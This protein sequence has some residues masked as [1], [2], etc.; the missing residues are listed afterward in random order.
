M[1]N[2]E[3][4]YREY[5]LSGDNASLQSAR[6]RISVA[7]REQGILLELTT[8]NPSQQ[9][10]LVV[11]TDLER[12]II[13]RGE[14]IAQLGKPVDVPSAEII[15]RGRVDPALAEVRAVAQ[16]M[17]AEERRLLLL[18]DAD[19]ERRARQAK[20][21]IVLGSVL[22]LAT[23]LA[24][25]WIVSRL[26][27]RNKESESK[28]KQLNRLYAMVGGINA[29]GVRVRDRDDLFT[30]ACRIAVQHGEFAMAWIGAIDPTELRMVPIAWAG[31]DEQ[32]IAAIRDL[33]S[34]GNDSLLRQTMA[35]QVVTTKAA[36]V[37]NDVQKDE[38]LVLGRI[39]AKAHIRSI[40]AL[41]LI[42]SD[43]VIGVLVLYARKAEFFD[44]DGMKLLTDLAGYIAFAV[45]H[46][47]KQERLDNLAY[48]DEPTLAPRSIHSA[49]DQCRRR[50][51]TTGS[52][53]D[54]P[55][56]LQAIQ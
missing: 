11:A 36:V 25:A 39:H 10:R 40:A 45:D 37:S 41:P 15:R 27:R 4:G 30:S 42:V 9:H 56:A 49:H 53:P 21:A 14:S 52:L 13:Q 8:D 1:E 34:T 33:L 32:T 16:D 18:R 48:Y 50:R 35:A 28:L 6:A 7:D 44:T 26:Q 5:A 23:A 47:Q 22:S 17:A 46:L 20:T 19:G 43:E 51:A 54:R 3:G 31:A 24:S 29:L 55:G 12:R 38:S 2:I